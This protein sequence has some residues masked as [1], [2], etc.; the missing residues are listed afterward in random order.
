M[1]SHSYVY[2][3]VNPWCLLYVLMFSGCLVDTA[4]EREEAE[5]SFPLG[6]ECRPRLL[7]EG[8]WQI[9]R[10][11]NGLIVYVWFFQ[12]LSLCVCCHNFNRFCGRFCSFGVRVSSWRLSYPLG[13]S[14]RDE[15]QDA[16]WS[17]Q[18]WLALQVNNDKQVGNVK[19]TSLSNHHITTVRHERDNIRLPD[20]KCQKNQKSRNQTSCGLDIKPEQSTDFKQDQNHLQETPE[21]QSTHGQPRL[22]EQVQSGLDWTLFLYDSCYMKLHTSRSLQ[23]ASHFATFYRRELPFTKTAHLSNPWNE[24]K[25]VKIGRDGQVNSQLPLVLCLNSSF[26]VLRM[27]LC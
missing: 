2:M 9:P 24:H 19:L 26:N 17:L 4:G 5:R 25:P 7:C 3:Y 14:C 8:K 22:W 10:L 15:R 1:V 27:F 11:E 16:G 20:E 18:D 12:Y 13:S 6:S 23:A 21:V